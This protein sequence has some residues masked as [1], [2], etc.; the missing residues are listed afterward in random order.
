M[1]GV[2]AA[3][4][5]GVAYAMLSAAIRYTVRDTLSI[6]MTLVTVTLT[7]LI[8]LG[9]FTWAR[10]GLAGMRA[11]PANDLGVMLL[12]G[13]FNALAFL[14]LTR[15]LQLIP[16]IYVNA[17]NVTQATMAAVAGV[18]LFSER[19]SP[20]LW[21]GVALTGTGLAL[22]QRKPAPRHRPAD[23]ALRRASETT[24]DAPDEPVSAG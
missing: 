3:C 13:I 10:I 21:L 9:V 14:A 2:A 15:S 22:M 23:T 1:A 17:L 20:A 12:A 4:L 24:V 19:S 18:M 6:P 8:G 7:G 5:S 16:L 11:T